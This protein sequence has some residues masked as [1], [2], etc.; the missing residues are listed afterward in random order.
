[1]SKGLGSL[2]REILAHIADPM[3][4][5]WLKPADGSPPARRWVKAGGREFSLKDGIYDLRFVYRKLRDKHSDRKVHWNKS[6][7]RSDPFQAAFSR[8]ARALLRDDYFVR[9]NQRRNLRFVRLTPKGK[10]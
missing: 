8:A 1:M 7:G 4:D 3:P 6:G 9:E 10:L 5:D 2:Q